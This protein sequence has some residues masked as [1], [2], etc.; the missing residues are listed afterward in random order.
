MWRRW[1]RWRRL[2]TPCTAICRPPARPTKCK[3]DG[4]TNTTYRN[5]L[6]V[7]NDLDSAT[8]GST[9]EHQQ[10]DRPRFDA[11][12]R[13][14]LR[15]VCVCLEWIRHFLRGFRQTAARARADTCK[16][17]ARTWSKQRVC[18]NFVRARGFWACARA[19][20]SAMPSSSWPAGR[21]LIWH[22]RGDYVVRI[23]PCNM[24]M[25]WVGCPKSN[26][27]SRRAATTGTEA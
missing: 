3:S 16:V 21:S 19:L 2:T 18:D 23:A 15:C 1:R 6:R 11:C 8:F 25:H 7:F 27:K 22:A 10:A 12:A 13:Q 14:H 9:Y 17:C 20:S 24:D 26:T 4:A 5:P